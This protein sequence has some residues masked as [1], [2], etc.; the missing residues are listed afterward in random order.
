MLAGKKL[1]W[2]E[3]L[4]ETE[5]YVPETFGLAEL[6]ALVE[7]LELTPDL[8]EGRLHFCAEA[9][10]R[11]LLFKNDLFEV[12]CLCWQ[13]EQR[14]SVHDHGRSFGV[15]VVHEGRMREEV[16]R[17][18]ADERVVRVHDHT[19]EPGVVSMAPVGMI[20]RLS[21]AGG[22]RS[23][24]VSLHFYA[25]PLDEMDVFDLESG[26]RVRQPMRYLGDGELPPTS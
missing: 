6:K 12:V 3:F 26:E 21:N 15:A 22:A 8:F 9:Y 23:R 14:T 25:G 4:V 19:F 7:R 10:A 18:R 2:D 20:H 24:L 11:N 5:A 13:G 17:S 1:G 16:F